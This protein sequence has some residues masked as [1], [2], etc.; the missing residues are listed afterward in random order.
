MLKVERGPIFYDD[1]SQEISNLLESVGK[2]RSK[3]RQSEI[4]YGKDQYPESNNNSGL[5]SKDMPKMDRSISDSTELDHVKI[6]NSKTVQNDPEKEQF[7]PEL[8]RKSSKTKLNSLINK[9]MYERPSL[10]QKAQY[11]QDLVNQRSQEKSRNNSTGKLLT[12]GVNFAAMRY[13]QH[14][15]KEDQVLDSDF[16]SERATIDAVESNLFSG[17]RQQPARQLN[18]VSDQKPDGISWNTEQ[19][20][21]KEIFI[22]EQDSYD[23]GH[24]QSESQILQDEQQQPESDRSTERDKLYF[25]KKY[26]EMI[27][28]IN[29][30]KME[31]E[32]INDE[33]QSLLQ[34]IESDLR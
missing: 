3:F 32:L 28:Q 7:A 34:V 33:N 21:G 14:F 12:I 8:L 9:V 18:D 24:D 10:N 1:I 11:E 16:V 22:R 31:M 25:T 5:F 30:M 19:K 27:K 15:A 23:A 2:H 4:S 17:K 20:K 13:T 6:T 26:Q 29:K